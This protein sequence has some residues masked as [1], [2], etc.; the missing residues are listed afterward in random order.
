MSSNKDDAER[1]RG[2]EQQQSK[3]NKT[4]ALNDRGLHTYNGDIV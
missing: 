4:A 3:E 2:L 1:H